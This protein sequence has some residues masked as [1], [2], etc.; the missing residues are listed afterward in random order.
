MRFFSFEFRA[1]P[2]S[3]RTRNK[4]V[5]A[6]QGKLLGNGGQAGAF[7]FASFVGS[8]IDGVD[9]LL[10]DH[11]DSANGVIVSG[12]RITDLVWVGIRIDDCDRWNFEAKR[13]RH[14]D[15]FARGINDHHRVGELIHRTDPL[16][17]ASEFLRFATQSSQFLFTH[18][19]VFR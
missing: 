11:A 9:E 19:R 8:R 6:K 10:E 18:F 2:G 12:D 7:V 15:L 13:F 4:K 14:S 16:E 5:R 1:S 3:A 17:V